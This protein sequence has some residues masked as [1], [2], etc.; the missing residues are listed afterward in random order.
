MEAFK[1]YASLLVLLVPQTLISLKI[2]N[3]EN[4][5]V[6]QG[7]LYTVTTLTSLILMVL[8]WN[9]LI[10]KFPKKIASRLNIFFISLYLVLQ[11]YHWI[12]HEPLTFL[13]VYKNGRDLFTPEAVGFVISS[14]TVFTWLVMAGFLISIVMLQRKYDIMGSYYQVRR[15]GRTVVLLL[16][17]NV[18][19]FATTP[20]MSN[21]YF[22]FASS[23]YRYLRSAEADSG[24]RRLY[25]YMKTVRVSEEKNIAAHPDRPHVFIVMLESFSA[26]YTDRVENGKRVT[27]FMDMLKQNGL[28]VSEFYSNS[29][30]TSKGQFSTLCSVYPSYKTNVFTSYPDNQFRCLSHI[31]K[32][33]GYTNVFMK[34]YHSLNF[35]NTGEFVKANAFDYVHGM[36]NNFVSAE[37]RK[38]YKF[39]WGIQ[40]DIFYR[41]TFEYLDQLQE[42]ATP[43]DRFF[44]STMSVTNHM[45]FDDIPEDQRYIFPHAKTHHENYTNSMHLTDQ[46]LAEFFKQLEQRDYLKNS[47]IVVLGDNGFPMGQHK[48]N[49]HNTK[50]GYNELFRT[51]LI[52]Q[53]K[54]RITPRELN[55]Q[56]YSQLDVAPT[57]LDLL[58]IETS[59]HF[60]GRSILQE[61]DNHFVPLIQPFDGTYL[62]SIRYPFKLIR[63]L[64]SDEEFLYNLQDD[65]GENT[66]LLTSYQVDSELLADL[67]AD[68]EVIKFNEV[69]L[70][71]DRIYPSHTDDD[72]RIRV[73]EVKVKEGAHLFFELVGE[74][75]DDSALYARVESVQVETGEHWKDE[76][77]LGTDDFHV[78]AELLRAGINRVY[79]EVRID[80]HV[81]YSLEQDVYVDSP[82]TVL[83]S[84]LSVDGKQGWGKSQLDR[85][86]KRGH[87]TI[88]DKRYEFGL[89]THTASEH[90]IALNGEYAYFYTGFGLNDEPRCGDG[91]IFEIWGDDQKLYESGKLDYGV[92][93]SIVVDVS[94]VTVL[95]LVTLGGNSISC[96]HV[97]WVSAVAYR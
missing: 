65:P 4:W 69:L 18:V 78:P 41:K 37:E 82:Q 50:T 96:D 94:G 87:L 22:E 59:H 80:D 40:D 17:M 70:E 16:C 32:E 90:K 47:L 51:P 33:N 42:K 20:S 72:F 23:T 92:A 10:V 45:M 66:N 52:I 34:A 8:L 25:P 39:G 36:D 38:Q 49:Y 44:V 60:V 68:I 54:G 71:E 79:F 61:D 13:M 57:V 93:E 26:F 58:G 76:I 30:E 43:D 56:A 84:E 3:L 74:V 88:D 62:A 28:S 14:V 12:R 1:R 77:K 31:L 86:V 9:A 81:L 11:G 75:S 63:H 6:E 67:Y 35:E 73:P 53:W 21:E 2:W 15:W 85:S 97:N 91:A 64:K 83:I 55:G 48:D 7:L 46:Y 89:G 5:S 19:F 95:R 24:E 29:V 27:P